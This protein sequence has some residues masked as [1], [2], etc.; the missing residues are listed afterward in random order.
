MQSPH[1]L[2]SPVWGSDPLLLEENLS[3]CDYPSF[4]GH[5]SRGVGLDYTA[6]PLLLPIL[7]WFLLYTLI[8]RGCFLPVSVF[9][10]SSCS[11]NSCNVC[12][13]VRDSELSVFLL[14]RLDRQA[15]YCQSYLSWS[16]MATS[17]KRSAVI[18]SHTYQVLFVVSPRSF[19]A[20]YFFSPH[21]AA[22][23]S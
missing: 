18:F 5:P 9:L 7:L 2:W 17:Q 14:H 15:H 8:C 19:Q 4:V 1:G 6:S 23:L 20:A 12:V 11:V 3:N 10:I 21:P 16:F 22:S 13:P